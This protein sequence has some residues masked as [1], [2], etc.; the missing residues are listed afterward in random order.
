[1][2]FLRYPSLSKI[3]NVEVENIEVGT[4]HIMP[5]IDGTNASIWMDGAVSSF[6]VC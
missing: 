5:K 4:C 1:M 3:G 6:L 2:E